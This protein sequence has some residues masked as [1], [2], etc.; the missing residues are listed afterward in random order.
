M[1]GAC[2]KTYA[3]P[4]AVTGVWAANGDTH[5]GAYVTVCAVK[6]LGQGDYTQRVIWWYCASRVKECAGGSRWRCMGVTVRARAERVILA[7]FEVRV[8]H[9][10]LLGRMRFSKCVWM[11]LEV[12]IR[13][14]CACSILKGR[15]CAPG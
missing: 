15:R 7:G 11:F 13:S 4:G 9:D 2:R 14:R 6:S 1:M 8:V 5:G 3:C 12:C 10:R